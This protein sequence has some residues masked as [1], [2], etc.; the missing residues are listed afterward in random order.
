MELTLYDKFVEEMN[1]TGLR[2]VFA[3]LE[4]KDVTLSDDDEVIYITIK[5]CQAISI[6][7]IRESTIRGKLFVHPHY[8]SIKIYDYNYQEAKPEDAVQ[9]SVA[10][11]KKSGLSSPEWPHII[12]YHYPYR[13]ASSKLKLKKG[14]VITKNKRLELRIMRNG[15]PLKIGKFAL[16]IECDK[17]FKNDGG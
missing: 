8:M 5:D 4:E 2:K 11:L 10:E 3:N 14:I 12:Y 6:K 1:K 7:G 15:S 17:W 16:K 13:V 9:F